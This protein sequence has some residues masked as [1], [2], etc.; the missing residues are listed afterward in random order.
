[1]NAADKA[2][3]KQRILELKQSGLTYKE[4]GRQLGLS[5]KAA[6]KIAAFT[7]DERAA[8]LQRADDR[9]EMCREYHEVLHGHHVN[10]VTS[11][12]LMI[13]AGCH[14]IAH[15]KTPRPD[16]AKRSIRLLTHSL[17]EK[18]YGGKPSSIVLAHDLSVSMPTAIKLWHNELGRMIDFRVLDNVCEFFGVG[19][20]AILEYVPTRI[21]P[22]T[23]KPRSQEAQ[24]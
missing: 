13:C 16:T 5:T 24:S 19:I 23:R 15:R 9:C 12:G 10:Y 20:G 1:M 7:P 18:H 2:N 14:R 17:I 21:R 6:T 22:A 4:V 8:M 3:L 11:E